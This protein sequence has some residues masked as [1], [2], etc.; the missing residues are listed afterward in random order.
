M[1]IHHTSTCLGWGHCEGCMAVKAYD[2]KVPALSVQ[3]YQT[4]ML[5]RELICKGM[6]PPPNGVTQYSIKA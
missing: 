1:P 3:Q 2:L 6:A 4:C 5:P